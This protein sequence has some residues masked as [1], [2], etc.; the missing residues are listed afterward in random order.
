MTNGLRALLARVI[1]YAGLFPPAKLPLELALSSYLRYRDEPEGWMLGRFVCP[2]AR[3]SESE[4]FADALAGQDRLFIVSAL[5]RGGDTAAAFLDGL[6][7]DLQAI[8]AFRARHGRAVEVDVLEVRLPPDV[9]GEAN[10]PRLAGLIEDAAELVEEGGPPVLKSFFEVPLR[11][12]W[13]SE[14]AVA[15]DVVAE[16]GGASPPRFRWRPAGLKLRTGGLAAAAFPSPEQVAFVIATARQRG[17]ALKFTAGLHHPLRRFDAGVNADMHGFL[18][19]FAAGVLAWSGDLGVGELQEVIAGAAPPALAFDDQGL[20]LG[21]RR[22]ALTDIHHARMN[23]VLS[24]G[25][26][27]FDEPRDDLRAL[28]LL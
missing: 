8:A 28:G 27:S 23:G 13:K 1:D 5:G 4:L 14:V 26:C 15:A 22:A 19:V 9:L 3:L 20:R 7:Q 12:D 24:F 2:A 6:R 21:Q 16:T 25:S 17:L 10:R 11:A 18:N